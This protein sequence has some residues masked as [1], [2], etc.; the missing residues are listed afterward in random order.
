[1]R[2]LFFTLFILL[3]TSVGA[4]SVDQRKLSECI[5][6]AHEI[7]KFADSLRKAAGALGEIASPSDVWSVFHSRQLRELLADT[8]QRLQANEEQD[9]ILKA[10][11]LADDAIF[12]RMLLIDEMVMEAAKTP[13]MHTKMSE[14]IIQCATNYGGELF[15]L[16]DEI[17]DLR[18]AIKEVELEL[19][20]K[21]IE[22]DKQIA[23]LKA[24]NRASLDRILR[25]Y[26][27]RVTFLCH[28]IKVL[29]REDIFEIFSDNNRYEVCDK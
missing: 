14:Y 19:A 24:Q 17:S 5:T 10:M 28:W 6:E 27:E 23:K 11:K 20:S 12:V 29:K 16:E 21:A 2:S 15:T 7:L 1:M 22:H 25:P 9:E 3:G 8:A 18:K 4:Q 13:H 26:K